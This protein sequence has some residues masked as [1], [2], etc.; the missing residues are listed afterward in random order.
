M[1]WVAR[2]SRWLRRNPSI[3]RAVVPTAM[4]ACGAWSS[5]WWIRSVSRVAASL[6]HTQRV[7]A[8]ATAIRGCGHPSAR[9]NAR[10]V[11]SRWFWLSSGSSYQMMAA[12]WDRSRG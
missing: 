5:T 9:P 7:A 6:T 10:A 8:L 1:R 2:A 12:V 11:W 3:P 4:R